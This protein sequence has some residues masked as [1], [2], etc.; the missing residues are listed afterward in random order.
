MKGGSCWVSKAAA[1]QVD[2]APKGV[3]VPCAPR[4]FR[5]VDRLDWPQI[6]V[7]VDMHDNTVADATT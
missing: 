3:A 2:S 6:D 7:R 4:G 1:M 5:V